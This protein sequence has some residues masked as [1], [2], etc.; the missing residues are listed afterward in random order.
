MTRRPV[1]AL[2]MYDWPEIRGHTDRLWRDIRRGCRARGVAA[3][4]RL[5]R[6]R[7]PAE[8]WRDPAL[9]LS[10]TCGLPFARHLRGRVRLL[11]TPVYALAECPPGQYYSVVVA[12]PAAARR[13]LVDLAAT[14]RFAYNDIGSQSGFR[15][16]ADLIGPDRDGGRLAGGLRTGSH[17]RSIRAVAEGRADFAAI[18]AVSWHLAERHE[19][20]ASRVIPVARTPARPGLPM[21]AGLHADAEGLAEA[22]AAALAGLPAASAAAL[23]LAGGFCRFAEQDY[24]CFAEPTG[25][26]AGA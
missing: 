13:R 3:P 6:D 14:G 9:V 22:V 23:G 25:Q 15:A 24:R 19:P 17:R 20:A 5:C 1:A 2:P 16:L 26:Q 11:G 4:R 12:G 21:I 10:Q 7:D 18:D 8:V